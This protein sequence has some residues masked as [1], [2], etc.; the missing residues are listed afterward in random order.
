MLV[1]NRGA[2]GARPLTHVNSLLL[3][4]QMVLIIGGLLLAVSAIFYALCWAGLWA[5]QLFPLIGKRD[6]HARW[7]DMNRRSGRK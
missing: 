1:D 4:A 3:I 7:D 6:R 5:V 2:W